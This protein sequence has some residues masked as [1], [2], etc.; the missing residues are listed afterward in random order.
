MPYHFDVDTLSNGGFNGIPF[1][2][3]SK[4]INKLM[5][6][7]LLE[8]PQFP[9]NT[10]TIDKVELCLKILSTNCLCSPIINFNFFFYIY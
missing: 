3:Q 4:K 7:S 9:Q 6:L 10:E 2:H 1:H 5:V 8:T